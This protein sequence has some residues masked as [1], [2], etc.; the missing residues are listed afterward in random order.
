MENASA[1]FLSEEESVGGDSFIW[2]S[3]EEERF[4]YSCSLVVTLFADVKAEGFLFQVPFFRKKV[5]IHYML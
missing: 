1:R 2:D 3:S 5:D 4:Y